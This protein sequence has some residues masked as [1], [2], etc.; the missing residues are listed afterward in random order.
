VTRVLEGRNTPWVAIETDYRRAIG[1]RERGQPVIFGD[2][3]TPAV[4]DYARIDTASTLVI[5]IPDPVAAR[6]AASYAT[7]RNPRLHMVARAHSLGDAVDLERVG[8]HRVISAE[9]QLGSELVRHTLMRYGISERE[10]DTIL[11]R[12]E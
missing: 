4:L 5:A 6:Q 1:A 8:V 3:G 9:R 11:R 2:A 12:R 10:I 7:T